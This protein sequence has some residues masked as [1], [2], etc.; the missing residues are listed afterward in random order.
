[1]KHSGHGISLY[2]VSY[3]GESYSLPGGDPEAGRSVDPR[4]GDIFRERKRLIRSSV[5]AGRTALGDGSTFLSCL[6][7]VA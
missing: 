3:Q 5:L 4:H 6:N 2:K 7:V 1:M